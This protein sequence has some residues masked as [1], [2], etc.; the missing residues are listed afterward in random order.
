MTST[1]PNKVVTRSN[2]LGSSKSSTVESETVKSVKSIRDSAREEWFHEKRIKHTPKIKKEVPPEGSIACLKCNSVFETVDELTTHEKGCYVK[3]NYE[4]NDAK[5]TQ[6]FSQK[7]LMNQHYCSTH[8]GLPFECKYCDK[9]F[10]S[11]KSRDR[12]QKSGH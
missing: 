8:L 5:Y 2:R 9:T 10:L 1:K 6:T 11:K 3:Y 4:C 7:S 12:H